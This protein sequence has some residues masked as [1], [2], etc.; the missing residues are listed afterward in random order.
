MFDTMHAADALLV[1]IERNVYK[2]AGYD[3]EHSV[4]ADTLDDVAATLTAEQCCEIWH[5]ANSSFAM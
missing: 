1:S 3:Y 5:E 2:L 4:R